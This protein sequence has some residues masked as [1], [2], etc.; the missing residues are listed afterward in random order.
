MEEP[1]EEQLRIAEEEDLPRTPALGKVSVNQVPVAALGGRSTSALSDEEKQ[2]LCQQF[3]LSGNLSA[4]ARTY[5]VHYVE[6]VELAKEG[7][8]TETIKNLQR[9]ELALTK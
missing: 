2:V 5:G 9:E 4:L 8:W 6:L 1:A 7:W 3:F